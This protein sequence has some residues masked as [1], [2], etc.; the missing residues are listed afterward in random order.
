LKWFSILKKYPEITK[1]KLLS[2][3]FLDRVVGFTIFIF[4]AF[5]ASIIALMTDINIPK[6]LVQIFGGFFLGVLMFYILV[7]GVNLEKIF[8]KFPFLKKGE[9][10]VALIKSENKIRI[11]RA[12]LV[13]LV[14]EILWIGQT[15]FISQIFGAGFSLL[16]VFVIIPMVAMVLLL[17]ISI[18]G[19]GARDSMYLVFFGNLGYEPAKI[20]AV[21][22]FTGILAILGSLVNGFANYF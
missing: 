2:S 13:S 3:I 17:P 20:L 7:F 19:I 1:T 14:T 21:S 6:Y 4:T 12:L 11:A 22:T 5:L 10:M 9:E 16:S 18:A 15:Y 8:K